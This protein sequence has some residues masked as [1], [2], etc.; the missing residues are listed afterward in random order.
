MQH[1]RSVR[2]WLCIRELTHS[3]SHPIVMK[4][5][6]CFCKMGHTLQSLYLSKCIVPARVEVMRMCGSTSKARLQ[7]HCMGVFTEK[8]I[9]QVLTVF[10]RGIARLHDIEQP[11]GRCSQSKLNSSGVIFIQPQWPVC[12]V[13]HRFQA[14]TQDFL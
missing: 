3:L 9:E 10:W 5:K 13:R 11:R 4:V 6:P 12:L 7:S 2:Y 14:K 1:H 8:G